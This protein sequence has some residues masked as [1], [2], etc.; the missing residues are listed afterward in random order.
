MK[1]ELYLITFLFILPVVVS[2][3]SPAPVSTPPADPA[4]VKISVNLIQIDVSVTDASGKPI[5]DLRPDEVEILENGQKQRISNFSFVAAAERAA[6][7]KPFTAD[8]VPEPPVELRPEQVRRTIALVVDDLSLSFESAYQTRQALRKYVDEKMQFGDLVAII[9]TGAGIGALQQFTSNR[10]Q[11]YAAIERVRWNPKGIGR[12]GS[13]DPIEPTGKEVARRMGDV[14]V[15]LEEIQEERQFL[16]SGNDFRESLFTAGTLGALKFIVRGMGELPGRKSVLLFSDGLKVFNRVEGGTQA[17]SRVFDFLKELVSDANR[18]SVVFYALDARGLV[19]TGFTAADNVTDPFTQADNQQI[20][21]QQRL[22][23]RS[24]ELFDS[25]QGLSYIAENTG[26]FAYLDQNDLGFGIQK[27]LDDQSYYLVGYQPSGED[28]DPSVRRFNKLE[29]RV[30]RRGAKVRHRTGF[31]V[32]EDVSPGLRIDFNYPTKIMRALTSP[33]A[34]NDI[35]LRLNALYGFSAKRGN[36]VHSFVHFDADDLEFRKLPNGDL[37]AIF[38]ILAVSY[39]DNGQPIQKFNASGSSTIHPYELEKIRRE[40]LAYSFIFPIKTPGGYQLRIALMDSVG[41]KVGSANQFVDV[42]NLKKTGITLSGIVLQ[43]SVKVSGTASETLDPIFSTA[44][45]QFKRGSDLAFGVEIF[46]VKEQKGPITAQVRVFHEREMVF[47]GEER[48]LER[49]TASS[50]DAINFTDQVALGEKL[51]PG[52]YILQIVVRDASDLKRP[53]Y[54]AQY[55]QFD[56]VD[57]P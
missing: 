48:K 28:I 25:Q 38:E 9:R 11:L 20:S 30:S 41:G 43:N 3:Q 51:E 49:S 5:R 17:A 54:S 32:G 10:E 39:G 15:A 33:F 53:R 29:V 16:Q 26:G 47:Q 46:N 27:V 4:I 37:S 24:A 42:P 21:M 40:G 8:G 1:V 57:R 23:E 44:K 35:G 13:F 55:V 45:R 56:V 2:G 19:H 52:D 34:V 50:S 22:S 6:V 14:E 7:K 18:K 12:F 31:F 36:F